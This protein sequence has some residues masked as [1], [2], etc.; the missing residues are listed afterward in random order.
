M[1]SV[2]SIGTS[3]GTG[4]SAF[5]KKASIDGERF[6]EVLA[7]QVRFRTTRAGATTIDHVLPDSARARELWELDSTKQFVQGVLDLA[8]E[9]SGAERLPLRGF[10]LST[11]ETGYVANR[12]VHHFGPGVEPTRSAYKAGVAAARAHVEDTAAVRKG[13]WLHLDPDRSKG[14]LYMLDTP[15][16][17]LADMPRHTRESLGRG[18]KTLLHE[19]NHVG[20][21]RTG[22]DELAW[23]SEGTA[24][25]FA[26]WPGRV[27]H[28]GDVLGFAVPSRVGTWFDDAGAPYQEEVDAVRALLRMSGIDPKKSRNFREAELLLNGVPEDRLPR[29][30]AN[31][32]ADR[33]AVDPDHARELR[34]TIR[35]LVSRGIAP[36]GEHADPT[37][38]QKLAREL[39]AARRDRLKG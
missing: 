14:I 7:E 18:V 27:K 2:P 31:A 23:L 6:S 29:A 25:T 26:R 36:D 28:A 30:I 1:P 32:V 3:L 11:S 13:T 38:V 12:A 9:V 20:S 22:G 21:P 39:E 35:R 10:T 19:I 8:N 37:S 24:E 16:A 15:D 4:W 34:T 5:L 33:H 17:T